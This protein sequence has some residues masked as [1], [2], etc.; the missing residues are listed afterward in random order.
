MVTER[1]VIGIGHGLLQLRDGRLSPF[2]D[3]GGSTFEADDLTVTTATGQK[4]LQSVSFA[5]PGRGLLAVIGPS[6]AG[7]STLLNALVGEPP[8]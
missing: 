7:K 2:V 6:G 5:L 3:A 4:L 8:R 1:D